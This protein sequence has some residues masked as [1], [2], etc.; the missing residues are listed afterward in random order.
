[1]FK[2]EVEIWCLLVLCGYVVVYIGVY[3]KVGD[4]F[5]CIGVW[6]GQ[7]GLIGLGVKMI[8]I[9]YDDLDMMFEVQLCVKVCLML[10]DGVLDVVFVLLV[11]C[12]MI[13]GG[14]YVVLLYMGLYV[15]LKMVY[16][17]FYGDWLCYLGCE[18]V[19]VLLFELYFNM[20]MDMV[21]VDLCIEI[22]LLLC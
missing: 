14:E 22:Y 13:V 12:V 5:G 4:V 15:D 8:G 9:F 6:V 7:Y 10:V 2:Y 16:Q 3:M 21:L 18:V 1:M 17:W 19:D 11:E 20:L